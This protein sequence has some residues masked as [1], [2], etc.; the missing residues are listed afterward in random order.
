VKWLG[1]VHFKGSI[2]VLR[3]FSIAI[4]RPER[5]ST[6]DRKPFT[7]LISRAYLSV[8]GS[9]SQAVFL[10][11]ACCKNVSGLAASAGGSP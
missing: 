11:M 3:W 9:C 7:A 6:S 2:H 5:V 8:V 4:F 1:F 10:A